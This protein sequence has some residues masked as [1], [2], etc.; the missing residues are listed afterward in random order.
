[1]RMIYSV[2]AG[3]CVLAVLVG[4]ANAC[5]TANPAESTTKKHTLRYKFQPRETIRWKVVHR[6]RVRTTVSDVTQVAE[7][8][9]T[10]VKAWRVTS[11]SSDGTV[12]FAHLVENVDMRQQLT[13]RNEVRY[14]SQ[15][16]KKPPPGFQHIAASIGVP[17]SI[18][19]MDARGKVLHRARKSVATAV[20][21]E[22]PMTIPLPDEPVPVG[23][24]W[25][26]P[27][28]VTVPLETGGVKKVQ[29]R[30]VF[31][32]VDVK[33]GIATVEVVNQILTPIHS[34]AIQAKL[35]QQESNGTI[36]FD[37]DAGRVIHQQIDLD[38]RVLGF[39]GPASSL[40]YLTR[41]TEDLLPQTARTAST[42]K[43]TRSN[44]Q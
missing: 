1:M 12:T 37:I 32:L 2:S 8:V 40:H 41:F 35:A 29:T 23:H 24:R 18:V 44:K 13:G 5:D 34:P 25:S 7:T 38:K 31:T 26:V 28:E 36:R 30:Q 42:G 22:G 4:P 17:L 16:D 10:S 3:L 9:S 6:G 20:Q 11:L 33:T 19:T 14:N 15:T 39:R 43:A 21:P 27:H